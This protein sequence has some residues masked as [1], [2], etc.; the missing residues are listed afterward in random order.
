[1]SQ[2]P[3]PGAYACVLIGSSKPPVIWVPSGV[4]V[5]G[6]CDLAADL[7]RSWHQKQEQGPLFEQ[8]L[9]VSVPKE[10]GG[11]VCR[12]LDPSTQGLQGP[13]GAGDPLQAHAQHGLIGFGQ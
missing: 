8:H 6:L 7:G 11:L 10:R 5:R 12:G 9:T 4:G 1:M 3:A 13:R 2:G